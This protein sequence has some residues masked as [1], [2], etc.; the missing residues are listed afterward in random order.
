MNSVFVIEQNVPVPPKRVGKG[1]PE[2]YPLSKFS[3]GDSMFVAGKLASVQQLAYKRSK[4]TAMKF[5]TRKEGNGVRV[6]RVA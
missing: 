5:V 1:R 4:K 3:V 2:K 6:W